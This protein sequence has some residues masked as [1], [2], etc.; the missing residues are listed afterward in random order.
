MYA[1]FYAGSRLVDLP[2]FALGLFL[3][4]FIAVVVRSGVAK[5]RGDFEGLARLPLEDG[6]PSG[7]AAAAPP[8]G[9][10]TR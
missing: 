3:A 4:T 9:R 2:L 7:G 5:R 1:Q 8:E 10:T 6:A